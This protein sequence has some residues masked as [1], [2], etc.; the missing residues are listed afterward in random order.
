VTS[1]RLRL[2]SVAGAHL[3]G[4]MRSAI[5]A[6]TYA[7]GRVS[8]LRRLGTLGAHDFFKALCAGVMRA[9]K[10]RQERRPRRSG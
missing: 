5:H 4:S 3:N 7:A 10:R 1:L 9:D 6:A 2:A 8:R